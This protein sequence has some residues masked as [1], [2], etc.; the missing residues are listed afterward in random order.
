[1]SCIGTVMVIYYEGSRDICIGVQA[2]YLW[3]VSERQ[4]LDVAKVF[5]DCLEQNNAIAFVEDEARL[6]HSFTEPQL[7]RKRHRAES[8]AS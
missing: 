4:R 1:M 6:E 2:K 5:L 7:Q 8:N 3:C